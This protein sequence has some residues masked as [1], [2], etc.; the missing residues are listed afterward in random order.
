MVTKFIASV[1]L[2]L[3]HKQPKRLRHGLCSHINIQRTGC[4]WHLSDLKFVV[5]QQESNC[6]LTMIAEWLLFEGHDK[7]GMM[8]PAFEVY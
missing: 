4:T 1:Q 3:A 8:L 2:L 6:L 5:E 7:L